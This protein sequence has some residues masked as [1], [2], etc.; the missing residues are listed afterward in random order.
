MVVGARSPSSGVE[1]RDLDQPLFDEAGATKR[2]HATRPARDLTSRFG[3]NAYGAEELVAE[4]GSAFW[5]AQFGLEQP[6][7]RLQEFVHPTGLAGAVDNGRAK[8]ALVI[9]RS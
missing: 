4:L 2:G 6:L 1:L 9:S 3:D 7:A 5:C 8:S